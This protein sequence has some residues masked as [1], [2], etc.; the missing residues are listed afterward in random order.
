MERLIAR[1]TY[2]IP[3]TSENLCKAIFNELISN[4]KTIAG[5]APWVIREERKSSFYFEYDVIYKS[6]HTATWGLSQKTP[7]FEK[8]VKDVK[9]FFKEDGAKAFAKGITIAVPSLP[10]DI[11]VHIK[12][13]EENGCLCKVE[14]LPVLYKQLRYIRD[15]APN[16]VAIQDAY[17]T[18]KRF[19]ENIFEGGLSATLVLEEKKKDI[20]HPKTQLIINDETSHQILEK[21]K[22]M[23]DQATCEVL[24]CGWVGTIILPRLRE[25]KEK[26]IGIRII[27]HQSS[28]LKGKPGKKEVERAFSELISII[29]Q[30]NISRRPECHFRVLVVDNKALVGS[31]DLNSIS[32]TGAHREIAIYTEDIEIV[33]TLRQYLN[34]IF[35][36]LEKPNNS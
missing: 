26:G 8:A 18:C 36:P 11:Y 1:Q 25:L 7:E 29:G 21:I 16:D 31:M 2:F 14:C 9:N 28:E 23:L 30:E 33:R 12:K 22:E 15:L 6:L 3:I 24:F 5:Y 20:S 10:Y 27:T 17:L 35:I 19:L 34:E 13:R 4:A 32:L